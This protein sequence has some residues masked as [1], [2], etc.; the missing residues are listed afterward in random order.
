MTTQKELPPELDINF[1]LP[2]L[3]IAASKTAEAELT[4]LMADAISDSMVRI[5]FIMAAG[6]YTAK[7]IKH[8]KASA[9]DTTVTQIVNTMELL[10]QHESQKRGIER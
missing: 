1:D 5:M 9:P 10:A 3:C 6:I 8:I 4:E 2:D 7:F